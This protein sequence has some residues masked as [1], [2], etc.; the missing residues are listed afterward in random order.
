VFLLKYNI[1]SRRRMIKV[2]VR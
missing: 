1:I 2:I